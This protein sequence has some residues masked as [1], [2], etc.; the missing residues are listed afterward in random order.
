MTERRKPRFVTDKLTPTREQLDIQVSRDPRILIEA[1]A[2]A[3][4]T[5]T[6]ALCIAEA[7]AR[8]I[9]PN[10]I[11]TLVFT[12]A[13]VKIMKERLVEV[14]IPQRLASHI[15]VCTIDDFAAELL[16][17]IEGFVPKKIERMSDFRTLALEAI[18]RM[19][20]NH[21]RHANDFFIQTHNVA[22]SQFSNTLIKLKTTMAFDR[23]DPDQEIEYAAEDLGVTLTDYLWAREFEK[24][25]IGRVDSPQFRYTLDN[26]YDLAT[27]LRDESDLMSGLPHFN[28]IVCDEMHDM[29]EASFRILQSLLATR[30]TRLI[31]AGDEDQVIYGHQGASYEYMQERFNST[32]PQ[33][34]RLPLT[35][36]YRHGPYLALAMGSFKDKAVDSALSKQSI[37][38][39]TSYLS[40]QAGHCAEQIVKIIKDWRAV[41]EPRRNGCAI[42]IRD[43]HQSAEIEAALMQADIHYYSTNMVGFLMRDETLLVQGIMALAFKELLSI[44][45]ET[46]RRAIVR[47][48]AMFMEV[49]ISATDLETGAHDIAKIPDLLQDFFNYQILKNG[50]ATQ[51]RK[52]SEVIDEIRTR[53]TSELAHEILQR[54]YDHLDME[55]LLRRTYVDPY[56]ASVAYRGL[57]ALLSVAQTRRVDLLTFYRWLSESDTRVTARNTV[58]AVLLECMKN[59]KG[60]EFDHVI[61]PYMEADETPNPSQELIEEENLFY[62]AAT[63]ARE[64]LTLLVPDDKEKSSFIERMNLDGIHDEALHKIRRNETPIKNQIKPIFLN[65][66]YEE[67]EEAKALGADFESLTKRW[68]IYSDID[69]QPFRRW[70]LNSPG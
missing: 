70:W 49:E 32:F 38:R 44:D 48:L 4:K 68:Y 57:K 61:I 6:L 47:S 2:G 45:S 10:N 24:L 40:C 52:L 42:L 54:I 35:F 46:K 27:M 62:V 43:R 39:T 65:V 1:N 55:T 60:K 5:T 66:P 20:I 9:K 8:G 15:Q 7:L 3:A 19:C 53:A 30:H 13:A 50:K 14:G 25:R 36:T 26:T 23:I 69:A 16:I 34:E 18:E 11:L 58:S 56:E 41:N 28:L 33:R 37:V 31:A 64:R 51:T 21:Q 63:R 29:N 59:V 17:P 22:I 12:E 67:H